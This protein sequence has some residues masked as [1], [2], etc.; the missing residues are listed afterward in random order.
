MYFYI[1][2]TFLAD[3]RYERDLAS[4]ETR[5]TDLGISGKIGRLTPFT[6]AKGLIRDEAKRGTQ[7]IVVVGNDETVSKVV[8]GLGDEQVVLGLIPIGEPTYIAES[9]G[10]PYGVEA[11]EVLSRR[12]TQKVDLGRVNGNYFLSDVRILKGGVVIESEGKFR[13]QALTPDCDIMVSNLRSQEM[14][15]SAYAVSQ[16]PGDPQDGLLDAILVP[17]AGG[18]R[19][20]FGRSTSVNPSVIPIR[21]LT[22]K[23]EEPIPIMADGRSYTHDELLIEIVPD[24]LKVI[25]GRERTF[26]PIEAETTAA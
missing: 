10:I 7:T 6:N 18:F 9:L 19:A 22:V 14:A 12:I 4:I 24:K 23:S 11:C 17:K 16:Q 1:Y 25:T 20:M 2:D 5:L 21:R 26:A 8:A 15:G 13:I 3:R